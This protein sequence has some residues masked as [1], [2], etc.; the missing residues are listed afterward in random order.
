M[1]K[2]TAA[3][4][5]IKVAD[6]GSFSKTA[7]ILRLPISTV[8]RRVKD[9]EQYLGIELLKRSTR[10]LSVTDAGKIYYTQV[11]DAV[12]SFD[13]AEEV[14]QQT[15]SQPSGII[16]IS[17]LPSYANKHLYNI[18]EKF[19][20]TYP[21]IIIELTTT[22]NMHD[23]VKDDIDFAIRPTSTPPLNLVSKVIDQ[24]RMAIVASPEYIHDNKKIES[25]D[26]IISHKTIC[27]GSTGSLMPWYAHCKNKWHIIEKMPYFICNDTC[28]ILEAVENGE[29]IALL[30][31]WTYLESLKKGL[32]EVINKTWQVSF[33][34]DHNHKL[35]LLYDKKTSE[36]KRNQTFLKYFLEQT[37][38]LAR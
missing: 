12:R 16:K 7:D 28:K 38:A 22:N 27:Y 31:E 37:K 6:T 5:F 23:L 10:F 35:C 2:L 20:K 3:R 19:R 13:Y 30:P 29:G 11:E 18:L 17:A 15:S 36:L 21:E 25:S 26:D 34:D 32:V 8:S 4:I 14:L 9:L 1:D 24:H 33:R